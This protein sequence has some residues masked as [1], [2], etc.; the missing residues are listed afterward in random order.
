[1]T[2]AELLSRVS[3]AELTEWMQFY[4]LEP[5]GSEAGYL[6]HAITAQVV[7][8]VNRGKGQKP[9]KVQDF[10]PQFEQKGQTPDQMLAFA[11]MITEAL[12]GENRLEVN[13]D[14]AV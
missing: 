3:S 13:D 2:V 11:S 14:S 6:G 7:A 1:M 4:N 8:N 5:F 12:G 10:L 9:Y